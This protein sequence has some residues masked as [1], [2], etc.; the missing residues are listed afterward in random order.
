MS[1]TT[2]QPTTSPV[3]TVR[4][5]INRLF[6][7]VESWPYEFIDRVPLPID[8]KETDDEVVVTASIPGYTR[9]EIEINVRNGALYIEGR[10]ADEREEQDATWHRRERRVG[11]VKRSIL[12]PAAV[13]DERSEAMLR[14]GVLTVK[15]PKREHTPGRKI[16]V[17]A[18]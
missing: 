13:D 15:L 1:I 17:Q 9:D 2:T 4:E 11:T 16:D 5:R 14:D 18:N 3:E 6:A 7:D 8:M 10:T 12:L